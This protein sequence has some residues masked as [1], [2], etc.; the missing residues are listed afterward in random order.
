[1]SMASDS[2]TPIASPPR[3]DLCVIGLGYIGLPTAALAASAGMR[4]VGVDLD[5]HII[6]S[7]NAGLPH[8]PEAG[9]TAL[10]SEA[11]AAGHLSAQST[12]VPADIF[13]IAVPTPFLANKAPDLRAVEAAGR[14]IAPHL[15]SGCL[16][17]L[18]STSP[19]RTTTA[20]LQPILE[21][22]SGLR[23]SVEFQL[24]YCP[25]RVLPGKLLE[26][27]RANDRILGG[28]TP[29][30]SANARDFYA[31]FVT[32]ALLETDA[33]TA[34]TVKLVE[35]AYRDVNIAFANEVSLIAAHLG[36]DPFAVIALANR[37]PRVNILE[38][39]IG[40]GG[41]CIG[42]DPWF[43]VD[44]AP[45]DANLIRTARKV[46]EYKTDWV[47]EQVLAMAATLGPTTSLGLLGLTYKPDVADLRESPA[48]HIALALNEQ[49]PGRVIAHDPFTTSYAPLTMGDLEHVLD[50][51]LIVILVKHRVYRELPITAW[52]HPIL[53]LVG[54]LRENN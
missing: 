40:V 12:P 4:V 7:V 5:A 3:A 8:F 31:R 38:P 15:T 36:L 9:L 18:E 35:N 11:V 20:I 22:G 14:A 41:H 49:L 1:M 13:L 28:V 19:P 47:A 46:N 29:Q 34:E 50:Q 6:E 45:D 52:N 43:L 23:A 54:M 39:G 32:G 37:H 24:A 21:A 53:D 2:P 27:L 17:I 30:A 51:D 16:V 25:E 44:A 48:V 26:E 10:V 42:V 33:T